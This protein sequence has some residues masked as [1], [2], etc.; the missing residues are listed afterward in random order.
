L[1]VLSDTVYAM[2]HINLFPFKMDSAPSDSPCNGLDQNPLVALEARQ[3]A[4]LKK[5][6]TLQTEV[7]KLEAQS[8]TSVS[9]ST[10]K[11][12]SVT[13]AS[14]S[15]TQTRTLES[16]ELATATQESHYKMVGYF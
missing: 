7:D 14:Q 8:K 1:E 5:L 4:I 12:T 6:A 2:P 9:L 3:E 16:S 15:A 13:V 11:S 10:S